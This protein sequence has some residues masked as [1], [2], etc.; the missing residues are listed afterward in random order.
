MN[1]YGYDTS[2]QVDCGPCAFYTLENSSIK[3]TDKYLVNF[4]PGFNA[5]PKPPF[6]TQ[7]A[8]FSLCSLWRAHFPHLEHF[9]QVANESQVRSFFTFEGF[10]TD[11]PTFV[12]RNVQPF[13]DNTRWVQPSGYHYEL[14]CPDFSYNF[15]TK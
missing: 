15:T 3:V 12:I 9:L 13:L 1:G 8:Q 6:R 4:G 14:G 2:G 5:C 7:L 10:C 11:A